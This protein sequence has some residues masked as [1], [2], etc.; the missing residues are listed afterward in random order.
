MDYIFIL[1]TGSS[2]YRYDSELRARTLFINDRRLTFDPYHNE[3]ETPEQ[4]AEDALWDAQIAEQYGN[5]SKTEPWRGD[6]L[7]E[8]LRQEP[9]KTLIVMDY[10]AGVGWLFRCLLKNVTVV[11]PGHYE[12]IHD[13]MKTP[14]PG[15]DDRW[16]VLSFFHNDED[17][18]SMIFSGDPQETV[19]SKIQW[20]TGMLEFPFIKTVEIPY[21]FDLTE[22]YLRDLFE[23]YVL[24]K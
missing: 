23:Q 11:G 10:N 17:T 19:D 24:G 7:A 12:E 14:I 5:S 2:C 20:L 4:E 6:I 9:L 22:D 1:E 15:P 13:R 16:L 18:R 8:Y 3:G 21:D